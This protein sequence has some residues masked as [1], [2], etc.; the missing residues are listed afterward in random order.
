MSL[1]LQEPSRGAEHEG[2][3]WRIGSMGG[4]PTP[5]WELPPAG[6]LF[7]VKPNGW[8]PSHASEFLNP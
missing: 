2:W 8:A 3:W 1:A 6:T 7:R 5:D 4:L